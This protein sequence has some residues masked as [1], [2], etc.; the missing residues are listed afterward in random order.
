MLLTELINKG[1]RTISQTYPEGEAREM[2]LLFLENRLGTSRHTHILNPSY[3]VCEEAVAEALTSFDRMAAGEPAQ[4]VIGKAWFYGREFNVTPD[5][6]IPRPETEILCREVTEAVDG[7]DCKGIRIADLC[8]G[9][10][11]IAWTLSKE[12]PGSQVLGVD[13]SE[14]ALAVARGQSLEQENP[15][16][17][18]PEF[19]L[20]DVLGDIPPGMGEFD[21]LVSNPPY[22]MESERPLMRR[23]VLEHEPALAL[24]VSDEDP[25]VF[26]R[27][28][29]SWASVLLK[30]GG[31][32]V[33]EINEALGKETADVFVKAGFHDVKVIQ[34]LNSRDRFV[35]A[36]Q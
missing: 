9:S 17:V 29:A 14:G 33:V 5:V 24:F 12:L 13:I 20:A 8:T 15:A 34:D 2:V 35:S 36:I 26:Y 28:V 19:M 30:K 31:L 22:V 3:E 4:Y 6:L 16:C 32:C 21:V 1:I 27:A 7:A 23:N 18:G 11:C 10:G 25:L